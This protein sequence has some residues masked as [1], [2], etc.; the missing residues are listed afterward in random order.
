MNGGLPMD[1]VD[2]LAARVD[3]SLLHQLYGADGEPRFVMLETIR[4]YALEQ[5]V[6]GGAAPPARQQHAAYYLA[7]AER[8]EPELRG[9]AQRAWLDQL[10]LEVDNLRAALQWALAQGVIEIVARLGVA[11]ARF[12]EWRDHLQEGIRWLEAA[13]QHG[14]ALEMPVRAAALRVVA[15]LFLRQNAFD[16]ADRY[17][18]ESLA[19]LEMLGDQRELARV[20]TELGWLL[21][22]G[23][24]DWAQAI[25]LLEASLALGRALGEP[26]ICAWA[27]DGLGTVARMRGDWAAARASY[28]ESLALRRT[29]G[30][31]AGIAWGFCLFGYLALAQ[32]D[33]T[34]AHTLLTQR[35]TAEQALDHKQGIASSLSSLGDVATIQ[36]QLDAAGAYYAASLELA[37]DI[38]DTTN[39]EYTLERLSILAMERGD[40]AGAQACIEESLALWRELGGSR[41]DAAHTL[42][43]RGDVAVLR[44]DVAVARA[45]YEESRACYQELGFPSMPLLRLGMLAHEDAVQA[46]ALLGESLRLAYAQQDPVLMALDLAALAGICPAP[47]RGAR[48][49]G[50]AAAML[51]SVRGYARLLPIDRTS[52]D[53]TLQSVRDRLEPPMLARA[54]AAGQALTLEQ[55]IAEA[56]NED[57]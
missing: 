48:L 19:L 18:R 53:R 2:D 46:T 49:A 57:G 42:I 25:P 39:I 15:R 20:R 37:R 51:E 34:E 47:E 21:V 28:A 56:L 5:L 6:S 4:E 41:E 7:L 8:A 22:R 14:A 55:A 31:Q 30:D 12:W 43:I 1:V 16:Q 40:L 17:L 23:R 13:L 29:L 27:L 24:D 38:G 3:K 35:L 26:G 11:L 32:G 44:G 52:Y 10:E 45:F 36:R 50:A 33:Y 9:P 54:W